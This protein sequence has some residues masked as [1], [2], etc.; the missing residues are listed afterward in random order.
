MSVKKFIASSRTNKLIALAVALVVVGIGYVII[1]SNAAG[2][3]FYAE[4][5]Q[6]AVNDGALVINDPIASGGKAIQFKE[7][8]PPPPVGTSCALPNYPNAS[9]TGVPAG[10]TLTPKKGI[11]EIKT[12]NTVI[13]GIDLDGCIAVQAANV[14]IRNSRITCKEGWGIVSVANTYSG[15]RL[16][17]EDTEISCG[18]TKG[19]AMGDYNFTARRVNI[20]SCENGFDMDTDITLEDSFIHDLI[21]YDPATDP[22]IDGIQ[23]PIGSRLLINHNTIYATNSAGSIGNAAININNSGGGP[24]SRDTTISNNLLAGGGYTLYCPI[25]S[26]VNF[27]I[28]NNRFSTKFHEKVGLYGPSTD[29]NSNEIKSANTFYESAATYNF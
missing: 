28:T 8:V 26:T 29:C 7:G 13:E 20:H 3:L 4:A 9:C 1:R 10:V 24:T 27:Q 21:S 16:L 18:G 15:G 19:T 2:F 14:I 25:P 22:H 11:M 12:A 5:E 23:S 17:V 6:G